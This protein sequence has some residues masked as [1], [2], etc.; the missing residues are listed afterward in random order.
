MQLIV[1]NRIFIGLLAGCLVMGCTAKSGIKE[2]A[3]KNPQMLEAVSGLTVR[4]L[5]GKSVSLE[6]LW[7]KRRVAIVF[8][9][10]FG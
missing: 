5:E 10:H 9:R 2:K 4:N 8:L 1:M 3:M 7:A 6:A